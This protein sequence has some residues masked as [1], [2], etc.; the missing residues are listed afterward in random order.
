MT[1]DNHFLGQYNLEDI[2]PA[3]RLVPQIEVTLEINADGILNVSIASKDSAGMLTL[4]SENDR[5]LSKEEIDR[6]VDEAEELKGEE[7]VAET[8][9]EAKISFE[10]YCFKMKK[11]VFNDEKPKE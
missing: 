9:V 11:K 1:K 5:R 6:M 10:K 4:T 7:E 8:N 3:P 2:L